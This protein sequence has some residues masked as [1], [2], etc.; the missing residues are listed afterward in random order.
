MSSNGDNNIITSASSFMS[1]SLRRGN[2]PG[3]AEL[4]G[5][6]SLTNSCNLKPPKYSQSTVNHTPPREPRNKYDYN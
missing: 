6:S 4:Y 1:S 3:V 2:V 5:T